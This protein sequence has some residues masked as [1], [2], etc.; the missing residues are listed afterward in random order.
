[1]DDNVEQIIEVAQL[2][3]D[4]TNSA[5][6]SLTLYVSVTSGYLLVAYLV[7]KDL[8]R[9]QVF[10]VTVLYAVFAAFNTLSATNY[11]YHAHYFGHTYGQGRAPEWPIYGLGI[12]LSLGVLASL[13]F[14]WD[15]RHPK[16]D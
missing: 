3:A 14:M 6:E 1:M 10:I 7:G 16:P 9:L 8:S 2:V 11:F 4:L 5:H 12:L 13:K 15:V